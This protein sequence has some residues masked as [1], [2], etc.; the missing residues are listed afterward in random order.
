MTAIDLL[1]LPAGVAILFVVMLWPA[2][3]AGAALSVALAGDVIRLTKKKRHTAGAAQGV[4][5]RG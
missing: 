1:Q 5:T 3:W 4:L 2:I